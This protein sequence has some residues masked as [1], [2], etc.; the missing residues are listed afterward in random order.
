MRADG[1]LF[2][3]DGTLFDFSAT[4]DV[5]TGRV[6]EYF[7]QGETAVAEAIAQA[8]GYD[9][10][11]QRL[12]PQSLVIAGTNHQ[13]AVAVAGALPGWN[14]AEVEAYLTRAGADVPL[15]QA[16]PLAPYLEGLKRL[17]LALGVMTNDSEFGARSHLQTTG[18][19]GYFDFIAG[20]DSG[21]GA[22]PSPEP[23]LAFAAALQLEPKR[24]VMVGDST[25][26]LI[27]G[28]AA[29]MLTVGVLT[30]LADSEELAPY[31]DVILP[32]IGDLPDWLKA[33]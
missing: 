28:Q 27:A 5:W 33:K 32:D 22:K 13:A 7:C 4:W 2:D 11:G 10:V 20:F 21:Y 19:E 16:V 31:A 12:L 1:I 26:D 18:V 6:I 30:G 9:L 24:V 14:V 3:K 15:A 17:G 8:V 25:H 29:G 23:L